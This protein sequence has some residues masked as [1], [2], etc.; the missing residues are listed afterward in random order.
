MARPNVAF[1]RPELARLYEQYYLIR[2]C[3]SGETAVKAEGKKYL[4]MPNAAD[5]SKE[6]IE[7]YKAYKSRAVF[8]NI[9]RNTLRGL[10]GQIFM[11]DAVM[12]VPT[13]LEKTVEDASG[14]GVS[15]V[16]QAKKSAALTL[17][18]S[19]S[20]LFVDFP[21]APVGEDGQV[22]PLSAED[23]ES[24]DYRPTVNVY[25]PMEII[26][27]RVKER[28]AREV[29]SL[30]VLAESYV[31]GDDGFEMK[32]SLQ[33]RVLKL[34]ETTG[35][36]VQ[37]IWREIGGGT[38]WDERTLPKSKAFQPSVT[39]KPLDAQGQPFKEIPFSF[40][41]SENND[42]DPDNPNFY[43]IC[44]INI[45]HYRNSAD[46]EEACF[47]VGQPTPVFTGLT[48]QWV[49]EVLKGVVTFGSRGAI[50]LP[51]GASAELLQ[52]EENTM[53]KE[54]MDTKERQ[55]VALGAKIVQEKEVQRTAFE[56]KVDAT[57]S[58]STLASTAK[59]V[60]SA[61]LWAL[62]TAGK[63]TGDADTTIEFELNDD[64]DISAMTPEERSQAVKDWQAGA[65]TFTEMRAIMRKAGAATEDDEKAKQ[66]IAEE[67]VS[68]MALEA[69]FNTP[70]GKKP[71]APAKK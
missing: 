44:S 24:G 53:I 62:V 64:F 13:G 12:K 56:A 15:L 9:A 70:D 1:I 8:Y 52:A 36:Y 41:G 50:P 21:S 19:R 3:M 34:D 61:Y 26:N 67:Q 68:Q 47:I 20:G 46:Y 14:T 35:D 43:D 5:Q 23:V 10:V 42:S 55:M 66:Q 45:A 22:R 27:W 39:I 38:A 48:K 57:A 28:G 60:S 6:N 69:P 4:P 37:E 31:N 7:R 59:N 71:P 18:Y 40:I 17:A 25:S 58:S 65:I 16:Q 51:V 63:F 30:I 11:R 2:D 32:K 29:Y 54:A 49:D 33:F